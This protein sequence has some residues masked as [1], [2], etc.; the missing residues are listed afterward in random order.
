[1]TTEHGAGQRHED[2]RADLTD[3][4]D[5]REPTVGPTDTGARPDLDPDEPGSPADLSKPSLLAVVKRASKEFQRDNLT[6]L[7]A[8]LTYYAVL[9]IVPGLIVLVSLLGLL[10]PNA[11]GELV[12]QAQRIAPGSSADFVRTLV[13]QAQAN[14]QGAGWGAILGFAVALWSASGYVAAFMRA[15]N[16]VYGIGEGRPIW[17]TTPI[18]LGVTIVAVIL[19]VVSAAIVV[20][21]G[22]VAEQIGDL[23]GLGAATV[24]IWNIVKWPVLFVLV[25]LL[26][27]ILF[28]ASPNARQGGI[29]WISPGGVIAV[30]V[31]LVVSVLFAVYIANFSSYDKTYGSLAGVVIFLVWLWLTNIALLLGAE[32]NAELDHGKAIAQGLPEEEQPFAVPRDTRKLDDADKEA[33]RAV[34]SARRE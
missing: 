1:M 12:D 25:S 33:V 2:Q 26:L 29:K 6:D 16:V 20:A 15:S 24:T 4:R 27:A 21:S 28:W 22:P 34:E 23:L 5:D 9:S 19:L 14:K 3:T 30:L 31:W 17:K 11:A 10:G 18:R 13:D 8:A 32:I 7:A